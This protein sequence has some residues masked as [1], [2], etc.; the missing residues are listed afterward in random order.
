MTRDRSLADAAMA[1]CNARIA[2]R[3]AGKWF[4]AWRLFR[5]ER[6]LCEWERRHVLEVDHHG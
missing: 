5:I 1:V 6:H 3:K 4:L 2:A